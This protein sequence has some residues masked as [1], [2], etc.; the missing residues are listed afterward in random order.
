MAGSISTKMTKTLY[1]AD[2][3]AT[4]P[5]LD[6]GEIGTEIDTGI[7]AVGDGVTRW[8]NLP[9]SYPMV[10]LTQAEYDLITPNPNVA[11]FIV[12]E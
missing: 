1:A 5:L 7:S 4:D 6:E 3:V 12:E 10:F 2:W 9:K 8:T 11:Y